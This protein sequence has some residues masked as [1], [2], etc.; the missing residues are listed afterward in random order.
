[1][2]NLPLTI[3][4]KRLKTSLKKERKEKGLK[5]QALDDDLIL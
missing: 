3:F 2:K 1:M 5:A 4:Q